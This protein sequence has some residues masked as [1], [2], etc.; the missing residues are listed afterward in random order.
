MIS[1]GLFD[2]N[3]NYFLIN[4]FKRIFGYPQ[5]M[6]WLRNKKVIVINYE[7]LLGGMLVILGPL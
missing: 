6:F 4:Q 7:L 5:H 2:V 3:R 1:N